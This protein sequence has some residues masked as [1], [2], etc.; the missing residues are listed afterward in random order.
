MHKMKVTEQNMDSYL[1]K[2]LKR[3]TGSKQNVKYKLS[4]TLRTVEKI[5]LIS[6]SQP[7]LLSYL[8]IWIDRKSIVWDSSCSIH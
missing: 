2:E 3:G 5:S 7:L 8:Y 1:R 4:Y 6:V